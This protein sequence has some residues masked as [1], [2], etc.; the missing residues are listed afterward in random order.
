MKIMTL[1]GVL[2]LVAVRASGQDLE[3]NG[4]VFL[5]R[6]PVL[7][8]DVVMPGTPEQAKEL[9]EWFEY[10]GAWQKWY[11]TWHGV[12]L[13]T[14]FGKYRERPLEP[15]PPAWMVQACLDYNKGRITATE[16]LVDSCLLK[17]ELSKDLY[18]LG[19]ERIRLVQIQKTN[20]A[21]SITKTWFINHVHLDLPYL[22]AQNDVTAV[23]SII[24]LHISL[25]DLSKRMQLWLPPGVSI[26]C[27]PDGNHKR[28][29]PGYGWG[30][31]YR[32]FRYR[33]PGT[34]R[35]AK[36]YINLEEVYVP[37]GNSLPGVNTKLTM[38]GFSINFKEDK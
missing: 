20:E 6:T 3:A 37:A 25:V 38:M 35:P 12:P 16:L 27:L 32:M 19:A 24:G 23:Y 21:E 1:C 13:W 34:T 17:K 18:D 22:L 36:F 9:L 31:G 14:P 30:F 7:L 2:L 5:T 26:I 8:A 4:R 33:F 11:Q 28:C 15:D 10:A 29:V